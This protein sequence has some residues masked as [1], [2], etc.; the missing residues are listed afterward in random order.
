MFRVS[1]SRRTFG[2]CNVTVYVWFAATAALTKC[3]W[4]MA[5]AQHQFYIDRRNSNKV[6]IFLI[7]SNYLCFQTILKILIYINL[8]LSQ[9]ST[10]FEGN[11]FRFEYKHN[12]SVFFAKQ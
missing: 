11:R 7:F 9:F 5:I 3:I 2:P 6:Y 12:I 1:V 10:N 4:S 8:E